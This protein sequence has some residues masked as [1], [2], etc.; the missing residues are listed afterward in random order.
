M[1]FSAGLCSCHTVQAALCRLA[2]CWRF[3][4]QDGH[5]R[6]RGCS[7][8]P[9]S[10]QLRPRSAFWLVICRYS[11]TAPW[12]SL[13]RRGSVAICAMGAMH[14]SKYAH[15]FRSA[16]R[17]RCR[18]VLGMGCRSGPKFAPRHRPSGRWFA[19]SSRI[20]DIGFICL[21]SCRAALRE[22]RGS[23]H[24][25]DQA[26]PV[27][28]GPVWQVSGAMTDFDTGRPSVVLGGCS[29]MAWPPQVS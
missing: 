1:V 12:R 16:T 25:F 9:Q 19:H 8:Q 13:T 23:G 5:S 22:E 14:S 29:V 28:Q 24:G 6:L 21:P 15:R 20:S 11:S 4:A 18:G 26:F 17:H 27:R 7:R 2:S 10:G 3:F